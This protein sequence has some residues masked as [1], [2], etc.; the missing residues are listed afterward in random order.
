MMHNRSHQP[1][2]ML[3]PYAAKPRS[4]WVRILDTLGDLL[5]PSP[6]PEGRRAIDPT[7]PYGHWAA[8][9]DTVT[10]STKKGR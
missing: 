7:M 4:L 2:W 1:K 9:W 6:A 5:R 8:G 3:V 10:P